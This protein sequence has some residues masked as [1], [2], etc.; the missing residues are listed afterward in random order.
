MVCLYFVIKFFVDFELFALAYVFATR[1]VNYTCVQCTYVI[2]TSKRCNCTRHRL[3]LPKKRK[4]ALSKKYKY[5]YNNTIYYYNTIIADSVFI[6]FQWN[7]SVFRLVTVLLLLLLF[8]KN[9]FSVIFFPNHV[10][11]YN[12]IIQQS[13]VSVR[14]CVYRRI[15]MYSIILYLFD[16]D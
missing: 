3:S 11:C 5:C 14:L 4:N 2:R 16:K 6:E 7:A 9:F 10:F 15:H 8:F 12:N 13:G 1:S